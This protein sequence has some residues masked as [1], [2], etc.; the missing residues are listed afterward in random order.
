MSCPTLVR[1]LALYPGPLHGEGYENAWQR[2]ETGRWTEAYSL[3]PSTRQMAAGRRQDVFFSSRNSWQERKIL[4]FVESEVAASLRVQALE[5]QTFPLGT[6]NFLLAC[7]VLNIEEHGW[8]LA[9]LYRERA[10]LIQHRTKRAV[11]VR[12]IEAARMDVVDLVR[13][14][15]ATAQRRTEWIKLYKMISERGRFVAPQGECITSLAKGERYANFD[16]VLECAL[17][18]S[19]LRPM[20][21]SYD[22]GCHW[23][24][25]RRRS[26]RAPPLDQQRST[27]DG[28]FHVKLEPV[29]SE[30]LED[31]GD[32]SDM[33]ELQ[34]VSDSDEE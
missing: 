22:Y 23:S 14:T 17:S 12:Q 21:I 6:R 28:N 31:S 10:T 16:A 7:C 3:P 33:P 24:L 11:S 32:Y 34:D 18:A 8:R 27:L 1:A 2:L 19:G 13:Y 20:T 5:C 15:R 9:Q 29:V 25:N 30:P 4:R 26:T